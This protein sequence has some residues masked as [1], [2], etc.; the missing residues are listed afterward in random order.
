MSL[1]KTNPIGGT[2]VGTRFS[3]I[4]R[5]VALPALL[6]ISSRT[7]HAVARLGRSMLETFPLNKDVK[8]NKND[9]SSSYFEVNPSTKITK[10]KNNIILISYKEN[11]C[12]KA[13]LFNENLHN[14]G[15][16]FTLSNDFNKRVMQI[17]PSKS[18]FIVF[19]KSGNTHPWY[20]PYEIQAQTFNNQQK[21]VGNPL[22]IATGTFSSLSFNSFP[23]S[24]G[25]FVSAWAY[26]R[27]RSNDYNLY[28]LSF[29]KLNN[30]MGTPHLVQT[31][32][33]NGID[34]S[35]SIKLKNK[36]IVAVWTDKSH[37]IYCQLFNQ[38]FE[39]ITTPFLIKESK[40]RI[41]S[42]LNPSIT[43]VN[44]GFFVVWQI[45][46]STSRG[47]NIVGQRFNTKGEK[48][49]SEIQ[50]NTYT[51]GD[52]TNPSVTE[53]ADNHLMVVWQGP[54]S[55]GEIYSQELNCLGEKIGP[56]QQVNTHTDGYQVNPEV[57]GLPNGRYLTVWEG[58]SK[59]YLNSFGKYSNR[60]N[61]KQ[62]CI[63]P[64][65]SQ[66]SPAPSPLLK[67]S[68]ATSPTPSGNQIEPY[69]EPSSSPH[70]LTPNQE[71]NNSNPSPSE[72]VSQTPAP[73]SLPC[74]NNS[75]ITPS[76]ITVGHRQN[77]PSPKKISIV[78]SDNHEE[79]GNTPFYE[80]WQTWAIVAGAISI[81]SIIT[82]LII[83]FCCSNT[84][85]SRA[86]D[87]EV[88]AFRNSVLN[89][90][91][92]DSQDNRVTRTHVESSVNSRS[93]YTNSSERKPSAPPL[94]APIAEVRAINAEELNGLPIARPFR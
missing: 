41:S 60:I 48:V 63:V 57:A 35:N 84:P 2:R 76:P 61:Q 40:E 75:Q 65:N 71:Q 1:I 53:L 93:D 29:D 23:L 81:T 55:P 13:Q 49:N 31:Y 25:G 26:R 92:E 54:G 17:I 39:I 19:T 24:E 51:L 59:W 62:S 91:Q 94:D 44:N 46:D 14:I 16:E 22:T 10:L 36:H 67:T 89:I 34:L 20:H 47:Y 64:H 42:Y 12:T 80:E 7:G 32:S 8:I 77:T 86:R 28:T 66:P 21:K 38:Y 87:I 6:L 58:N 74:K 45:K 78:K 68:P 72:I 11:C 69:P 90:F 37:K 5:K 9:G 85:S 15:S 83:R 50:I 27:P 56:E 33:N 70:T 88:S 4:I 43:E 73:S 82:M 79:N 3:Q 30:R 52:Q 18:N